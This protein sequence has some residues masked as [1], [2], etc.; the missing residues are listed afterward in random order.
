MS[1]MDALM[2]KKKRVF[3]TTSFVLVVALVAYPL[4]GGM[5]ISFFLQA[6]GGDIST[7]WENDTSMSILRSVQAAAQILLLCL[8]AFFLA[9]MQTG[10]KWPF[11]KDNFA[12]LGLTRRSS[13]LEGSAIAVVGIVL[14]QPFLYVVMEGIGYV[15]LHFG[16]FGR[17]LVEQQEERDR[18]LENFARADFPGEFMA[19]SFVV[20]VVPAVCEEVFFRGYIQKNYMEALSPVWGIFLTG[21]VFGLF[22]MSPTNLIPLALM[23]WYLGFVYFITKSLL[24][25]IAV[26][27][28]NNFLSVVVLQVSRDNS[29]LSGLGMEA[30][31]G[32]VLLSVAVSLLLFVLLMRRLTRVFSLKEEMSELHAKGCG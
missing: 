13:I 27:F 18:F 20:A 16:E 24:A 17:T 21:L 5:M 11:S 14:L 6:A 19:V 2:K 25:P 3:Y 29:D 31:G 1:G 22:H 30:S 26:H 28:C 4:F 12:F 9:G 23:G 32:F 15:L 10:K 8:P 7:L